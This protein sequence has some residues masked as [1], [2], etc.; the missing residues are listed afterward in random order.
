MPKRRLYRDAESTSSDSDDNDD[1][2]KVRIYD[3]EGDS[4]SEEEETE[5]DPA[6]YDR[7]LALFME[8]LQSVF[9]DNFIRR[10]EQFRPAFNRLIYAL[11]DWEHQNP[12]SK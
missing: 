1:N 7:W 4:E 5:H 12:M 8:Q 2:R 9:Y 11:E 6:D 3:K 10:P